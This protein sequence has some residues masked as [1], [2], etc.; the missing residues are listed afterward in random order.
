MRPT[1]FARVTV[2]L[3]LTAGFPAHVRPQTPVAAPAAQ[4][5]APGAYPDSPEGLKSLLQDLFAWEKARDKRKSSRYLASF[6]IPNHYEWFV[7][8]FGPT[9]GARLSMKYTELK[10]ESASWL[11]KRVEAAVKDEK[12]QVDV[13]IY[14]NPP[15]SSAP[16][17]QAAL[18]AMV[19]HIAIYSAAGRLSVDDKSPHY[20]GE[21]IYLDGEFR[22]VERQVLQALS[23]APPQRI[24]IGGNVQTAKLIKKVEPVYPVLARDNHI[25]GTVAL[26]AIVATDGTIMQVQVL[27]GDPALQAAAVDAVRQWQYQPTLLNGIPVEVDTLI[28]V[29]FTLTAG[30]DHKS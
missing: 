10:A 14:R 7:N 30:P 20:L 23:T 15:D 22:Y 27:G 5:I 29:E 6:A 11:Q 28:N 4:S 18:S 3:L 2:L 16:L 9:E 8:T 1:Y 25:Q 24:R 26:H 13:S 12:T 21:F 17:M 19:Q